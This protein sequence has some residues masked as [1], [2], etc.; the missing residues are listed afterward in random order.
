MLKRVKLLFAFAI[1]LAVA[2]TACG[3]I[4]PGDLFGSPNG[5]RDGGAQLDGSAVADADPPS[6]IDAA[7]QDAGPGEPTQ[8][9]DSN[10]IL[11]G[12]VGNSNS[13]NY[14]DAIS[15][16][17]CAKRKMREQSTV[18]GVGLFSEFKCLENGADCNGDLEAAFKCDGPEDCSNNQVCCG[19]FAGRTQQLLGAWAEATC[20]NATRCTGGYT[21]NGSVHTFSVL[22]KDGANPTECTNGGT[23]TVSAAAP[24]YAYCR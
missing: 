9:N 10:G 19:D 12:K 18:E 21:D 11:C 4:E 8:P 7:P 15:E 24:L 23:C 16:F 2:I 1:P 6:T 5:A 3:S 22:C 14:C 13:D 20:K 17:C